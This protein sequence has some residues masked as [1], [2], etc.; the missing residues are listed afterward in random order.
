MNF[1]EAIARHVPDTEIHLLAL[2]GSRML[3]VAHDDSDYDYFGLHAGK[4]AK[5]CYTLRGDGVRE[6]TFFSFD[7]CTRLLSE[8]EP[9][10]FYQ[11]LS[12]L[13]APTYDVKTSEADAFLERVRTSVST[14][15]ILD[16]L[17]KYA[18][19]ELTKETPKG[20]RTAHIISLICA[21]VRATG[22]VM[23]PPTKRSL[24]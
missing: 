21:D 13:H 9:E 15:R 10:E 6:Y 18:S 2:L 19:L 12:L 11:A 16:T 3:G 4:K 23:L 14:N 17:T 5:I 20:E 8:G 24:Q 7:E 22:H 1:K